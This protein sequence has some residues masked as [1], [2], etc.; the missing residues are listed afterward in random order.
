MLKIG[1]GSVER[2]TQSKF[3]AVNERMGNIDSMRMLLEWKLLRL[4]RTQQSW[5]QANLGVAHYKTNKKLNFSGLHG[6]FL[7]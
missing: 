1:Q 7:E 6:L 3:I 2:F 4:Y 5:N